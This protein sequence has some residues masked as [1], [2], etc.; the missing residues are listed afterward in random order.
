MLWKFLWKEISM[1]EVNLLYFEV[2][3]G[4]IFTNISKTCFPGNLFS[5]KNRF[6]REF[7]KFQTREN[8]Q[9]LLVS[10]LFHALVVLDLQ[11][12]VH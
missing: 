6:S 4:P 9:M 11:I 1:D 8:L 7:I 5:T 12:S 10:M 2:S 3:R